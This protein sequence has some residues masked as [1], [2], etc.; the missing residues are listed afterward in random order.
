MLLPRTLILIGRSG[1]GKGTQAVKLIEWLKE[2]YPD[3][4]TFYVKTGEQF[5][6][7]IA[8]NTYT[9]QLTKKLLEESKLLPSFLPVWVWSHLLIEN[10]KGGEH[11]IFDGTP[12]MVAEAVVLDSVMDFY[13]RGK[14]TV[15]NLEISRETALKRLTAR[16]RFDDNSQDSINRR[17]DWFETEVVPVI[18]YF[19]R[20]PLYGVLDIDGEQMIE[21]IHT[22][23]VSHL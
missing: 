19:R 23:I 3:Q 10:L 8:G 20:S 18:E 2:Q 6:Q 12:R 11:L 22:D 4:H 17:L 5:R 15:I 21:D 13:N 7:L 9:G 16:G 1:A 14:A